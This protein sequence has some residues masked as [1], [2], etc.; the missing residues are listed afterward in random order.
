[1][2]KSSNSDGVL[3][4]KAERLEDIISDV[5]T[6]INAKGE[7]SLILDQVEVKSFFGHLSEPSTSEEL[8]S[9]NA[10]WYVLSPTTREQPSQHFP[11]EK[12]IPRIGSSTNQKI[13]S[14]H[15][16]LNPCAPSFNV[17]I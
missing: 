2:L 15:V 5:E 4:A 9:L 17:P 7:S 12:E 3:E 14:D 10:R 1:M 6:S 16:T 13:I 11:M 8:K